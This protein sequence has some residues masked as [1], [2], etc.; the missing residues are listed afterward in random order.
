MGKRL[1]IF[2]FILMVSVNYSYAKTENSLDMNNPSVQFL[3][4]TTDE[5]KLIRANDN[6]ITKAYTEDDV[7]R[8]EKLKNEFNKATKRDLTDKKIPDKK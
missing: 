5:A 2:V 6:P 1:F 4:K 7:S 3:K 8:V